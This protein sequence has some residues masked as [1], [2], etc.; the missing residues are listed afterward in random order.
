[1]TVRT[2]DPLFPSLVAVIVAVPAPTAVT[3]PV[4]DTVA[5]LAALAVHVTTRSVTTAPATFLTSAD[6]DAV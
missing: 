2:D 1:V 3:P 4:C 5:T 6:R